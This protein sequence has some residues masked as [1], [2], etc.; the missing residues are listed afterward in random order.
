MF[1]LY[2][3]FLG[4]VVL[5]LSDKQFG[6]CSRM[7]Q[8]SR[9]VSRAWSRPQFPEVKGAATS[10]SSDWLLDRRPKL[11]R[12]FCWKELMLRREEEALFQN[13]SL[14]SRC[15]LSGGE[16]HPLSFSLMLPKQE[17]SSSPLRSRDR[18]SKLPRTSSTASVSSDGEFLR[19]DRS[20]CRRRVE[21]QGAVASAPSVS[22]LRRTFRMVPR[23]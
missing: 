10:S 8:M 22:D 7:Q 20:F 15:P 12:V 11:F 19:R 14:M 9:W 16:T 2:F 1:L 4:R 18:K 23:C 17:V 3:L 5:D 21:H 13:A 6:T